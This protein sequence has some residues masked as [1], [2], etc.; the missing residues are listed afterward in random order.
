M[1]ALLD[2]ADTAA[3]TQPNRAKRAK[4]P[5]DVA[6]GQRPPLKPTTSPKPVPVKT[7]TPQV[8]SPSTSPPPG[9]AAM[10][11]QRSS[12]PFSANSTVPKSPPPQTEFPRMPSQPA[13]PT[14]FDT[15][16]PH[17]PESQ[18]KIV[19]RAVIPAMMASALGLDNTVSAS[20]YRLYLDEVL[21]NVEDTNDIVE[22]MLCEQLAFAHL[23]L[24]QLHVDAGTAKASEIRK[25]A[26]G[27]CIRLMAEFRKTAL[28][29]EAYR[30]AASQRRLRQA[31]DK[32][33][34]VHAAEPSK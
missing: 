30:V 5:N 34:D 26:N 22:T 10:L 14:S 4:K 23:R 29:L 24:A 18:A 8:R 31:V 33:G 13:P 15:K 1:Q 12:Q 19:E 2:Q 25:I 27:S 17:S 6:S 7:E 11:R 3:R 28:A 21:K 20:G 32:E 9:P 16:I